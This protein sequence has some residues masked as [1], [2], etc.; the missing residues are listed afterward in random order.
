M[1]VA[2]RIAAVV[3]PAVVIAACAEVTTASRTS[4]ATR[5]AATTGP[6]RTPDTAPATV[7]EQPTPRDAAPEALPPATWHEYRYRELFTGMLPGRT[8]VE[9]WTFRLDGNSASTN[10]GRFELDHEIGKASHNTLVGGGGLGPREHASPLGPVEVGNRKTYLGHWEQ[11][12]VGRI[13]LRFEAD[14]GSPVY[15]FWGGRVEALRPEALLMHLAADSWDWRPANRETI[16]VLKCDRAWLAGAPSWT[17]SGWPGRPNQPQPD[18]L[19][20]AELPGLEYAHENDDE[21]VQQGALRKL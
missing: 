10:E 11:L 6:A 16:D 18:M 14:A 20:F 7:A 15:C 8:Q 21:I 3:V 4:P 9:T 12:D 2:A 17:S 1:T 13:L 5:R 19:P